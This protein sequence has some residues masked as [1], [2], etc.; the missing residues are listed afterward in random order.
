[1]K[2]GKLRGIIGNALI[3]LFS[4]CTLGFMALPMFSVIGKNVLT[5]ETVSETLGSVFD[6]MGEIGKNGMDSKLQGSLA[7]FIIV[8]ILACALMI[9]S[10]VGLVA[11]FT[12]NKKLNMTLVNRI[13]TA[14][15]TVLALVAMILAVACTDKSEIVSTAVNAGAIMPLVF[16]LF[17]VAGA[18]VAPSKKKA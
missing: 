3:L 7:L 15:M 5:G 8:A 17:T 2:A 4:I 16:S 9:T 10:I 18:I 6:Y 13:V 1:M 11:V 12:K 14:L